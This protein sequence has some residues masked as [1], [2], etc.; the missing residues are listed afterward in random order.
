MSTPV[1]VIFIELGR[2]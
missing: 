2:T 1:K